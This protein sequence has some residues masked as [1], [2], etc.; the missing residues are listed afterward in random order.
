M[1][2]QFPSV[3]ACSPQSPYRGVHR[4]QG[5]SPPITG[6]GLHSLQQP[7]APNFFFPIPTAITST[8][9]VFCSHWG[10]TG[11]VLS[12][13]FHFIPVLSP[14]YRLIL[15]S[16][17]WCSHNTQSSQHNSVFPVGISTSCSRSFTLFPMYRVT[18]KSPITAM[19]QFSSERLHHM[20][21]H[22]YRMQFLHADESNCDDSSFSGDSQLKIHFAGQIG[23]RTHSRTTLRTRS[24]L[25]SPHN[26]ACTP[27][28]YL[29][30]AHRVDPRGDRLWMQIACGNRMPRDRNRNIAHL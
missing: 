10:S 24:P 13:Q 3:D 18:N 29:L 30:G 28:A 9:T 16:T 5:S 8:C 2:L 22:Q 21:L 23:A 14:Q 6:S 15:H 19:A 12:A 7:S 11:H 1:K 25:Q 27:L 20:M 17:K 4:N 26:H